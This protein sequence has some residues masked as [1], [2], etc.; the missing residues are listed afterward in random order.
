MANNIQ[1]DEGLSGKYTETEEVTSGIHRQAVKIAGVSACVLRKT[2]AVAQ[3]MVMATANTDYTITNALAVGTKY[4]TIYCA[5]PFVVA[6]GESTS[7]TCGV[8]LSA[9][10]WTFPVVRSGV[11][12]D[13]RLHAQSSIAGAIVRLTEMAD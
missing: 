2:K 7:A 5:S 10:T 12:A 9:G 11:S 4:I 3:V 6:M 13:D 8:A 1:L